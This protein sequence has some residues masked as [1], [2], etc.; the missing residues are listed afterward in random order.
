MAVPKRKHSNARTQSRRRSNWKLEKTNVVTCPNCGAKML[1]HR[2]CE[3]CG[4]YDKKQIIEVKN[5]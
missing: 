1:P 3:A 5:K 2:V 4:F